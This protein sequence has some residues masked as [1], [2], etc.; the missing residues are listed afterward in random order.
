VAKAKK[1]LFYTVYFWI[2]ELGA[3][4]QQRM[5]VYSKSGVKNAHYPSR[6]TAGLC[7]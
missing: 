1:L 3:H 7:G 4:Y 2:Q 5:G 6:L